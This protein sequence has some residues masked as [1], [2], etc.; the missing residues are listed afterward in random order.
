MIIIAICA[1]VLLTSE[2][3]YLYSSAIKNTFFKRE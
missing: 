3:I 2:I 1:S